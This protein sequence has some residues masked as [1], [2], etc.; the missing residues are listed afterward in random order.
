MGV[1]LYMDSITTA[2][3]RLEFVEACVEVGARLPR[4]VAIRLRDGSICTVKVIIPWFPSCCSKCRIFG[5]S[6]KMCTAGGVEGRKEW[7]VKDK[8]PEMSDKLIV[9][10]NSD[11]GRVKSS[12]GLPLVE[13]GLQA[14]IEKEN[15]GQ[16]HAADNDITGLVFEN[17][18]KA[19]ELSLKKQLTIVVVNDMSR[20]VQVVNEK[21]G[22]LSMEVQSVVGKTMTNMILSKAA[23]CLVQGNSKGDDAL[24]LDPASNRRGRGKKVKRIRDM[25]ALLTNSKFWVLCWKR[26]RE[27]VG[28]LD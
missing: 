18:E 22:E 11:Q 7:R 10:G 1:P 19:G 6:D 17:N 3:E 15:V 25:L 12:V 5:H 8:A 4:S 24:P 27:W 13:T 16:N 26:S 28:G 20:P 21:T 2:K 23:G 9:L 14:I